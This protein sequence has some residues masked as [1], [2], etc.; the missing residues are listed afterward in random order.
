MRASYQP[1]LASSWTPQSGGPGN[2]SAMG[3]L[4]QAVWAL[5]RFDSFA[6]VVTAV[7]DFGKDTDSV[8]AVAG[9]LA[10]AKFGIQGIPSRWVTYLHGQVTD[11]DGNVHHYDHLALQ[12]LALSLVGHPSIDDQIDEPALEPREVVPGVWASNR[13]GA[14]TVPDDWAIVSLCRIDQSM[15]RPVRREVYLIDRDGDH[16]PALATVIDDVL[17]S[18]DA[19]LAE[20]RNVLVHCHGGRSR[21]GLVLAAHMMRH[22]RSLGDAQA[23]LVKTWPDAYFLNEAFVDE[24]E[25]RD[26]T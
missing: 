14:R 26:S 5:R 19:L 13:S 16:N 10:G 6:G 18:I 24:L 20:D 9:A 17:D 2:G 21:T 1:L 12:Q 22:G 23:F 25:L 11:A 8:A 3:A 15:R 4:A 7:I